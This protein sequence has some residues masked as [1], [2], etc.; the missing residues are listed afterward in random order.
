MAK[1][2]H[3][4]ERLS[5][6]PSDDSDS[7]DAKALFSSGEKLESSSFKE[8][9]QWKLTLNIFTIVGTGSGCLALPYAIR[10][11]GIIA[12]VAFVVAPIPLGFTANLLRECLDDVDGDGV[13][14]Y[15]KRRSLQEIAR[16]CWAPLEALVIVEICLCLVGLISSNTVLCGSLMSQHFPSIPIS[17]S[18]WAC[19]ATL[20]VL[21]FVFL[22]HFS[23][24]AWLSLFG[25]VSFIAAAGLLFYFEFA[26]IP[27]WDLSSLLFFDPRGV[28]VSLSI[29]IFTYGA[30]IGI[31]SMA[32]DVREHSKLQIALLSSYFF[33]ALVKVVFSLSG[34]LTFTVNTKEVV[35][36]NLPLGIPAQGIAIFFTLNVILSNVVP[37]LI[38]LRIIEDLAFY[39][40]I[41]SKVQ[42]MVCHV[43]IRVV[44]VG[45]TL[46]FALAIP[47]FALLN[48]LA[49]TLD[50][51]H[52]IMFPGLSVDLCLKYSRLTKWQ[53]V[54][55]CFFSH[56]RIV[57][58]YNWTSNNNHFFGPKI[59]A[60]ADAQTSKK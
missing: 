5:T 39:Q 16:D 49:G 58:I 31:T 44:L 47:H 22:K 40:V 48:A 13:V 2:R 21:P 43:L 42:P 28:F 56:I 23:H 60:S 15:R 36:N 45:L 26:R 46:L 19:L 29:I 3:D 17:E 6:L 20:F 54:V 27:Q 10:E 35:F 8:V 50:F 33:G 57:R 9:S 4:Y 18:E 55:D 53:V 7:P 38:I 52:A 11:G 14:T 37:F 32:A 51:L 34:F 30:H 59:L 41:Y 24:I 1:N 12:L 25:T